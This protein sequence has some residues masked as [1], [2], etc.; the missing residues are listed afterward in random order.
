MPVWQ[1]P[2]DVNVKRPDVIQ[3]PH[4]SATNNRPVGC[5]EF[6]D[7]IDD[8]VQ[9]A[10]YCSDK[11]FCPKRIFSDVKVFVLCPTR[12]EKLMDKEQS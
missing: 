2:W 4:S 11:T 1:P 5:C 7:H 3:P 8:F 12:L 10:G 9:D 6:L